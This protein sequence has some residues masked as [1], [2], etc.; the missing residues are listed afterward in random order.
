MQKNK[1]VSLL[2]ITISLVVL[3]TILIYTSQVNKYIYGFVGFLFTGDKPIIT[4]V[5]NILAINLFVIGMSCIPIAIIWKI[6]VKKYSNIVYEKKLFGLRLN[7][8][9]LLYVGFIILLLSF[10][11]FTTFT[12]NNI[13]TVNAYKLTGFKKTSL[14]EIQSIRINAQATPKTTFSRRTSRICQLQYDIHIVQKQKETYTLKVLPGS[15]EVLDNFPEYITSHRIPYS[16][17]YEN[18]CKTDI[19]K[20][21]VE[22]IFGQIR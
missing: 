18:Y 12:N 15:R 14:S 8:I 19:Y 16:L 7:P 6:C 10:G 17:S 20:Q 3:I 4:V 1:K 9:R 21:E 11:S 13:Y 22:S 2:A 5:S